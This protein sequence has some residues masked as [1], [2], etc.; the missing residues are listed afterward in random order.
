MDIVY[1]D[2]SLLIDNVG[3]NAKIDYFN[4]VNNIK[5]KSFSPHS[6]TAY[7][8]YFIESGEMS[9]RFEEELVELFEHD[10]MII[11]PGKI[12]N[13]EHCSDTLKRFNLRFLFNDSLYGSLAKDYILYRPTKAIKEEIYRNILSI[14][15]NLPSINDRLT[16]FRIKASL[17]IIISHV[18]G[19]IVPKNE[20]KLREDSPLSEHQNRLSQCILIDRFFTDNYSHPV[21]ADALAEQLHYSKTHL[22]R[23]LK[24]YWG[25]SFTEKLAH[26]RLHAAMQYLASSDL[27]VS[28]IA[29]K[30]GYSSLRGFEIFFSKHMNM[31]PLEYRTRSRKSL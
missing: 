29:E 28:E 8:V 6:H 19:L 17:G 3:I 2:F 16:L 10:V 30:C 21:T 24:S 25:M 18:I 27:T 26:T 9:V 13:V 1:L 22:N 7:E 4:A 12:H 5:P 23:L 20:E 15:E 14:H 31:L 11:P